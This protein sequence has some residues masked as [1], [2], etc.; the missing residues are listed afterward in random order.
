MYIPDSRWEEPN[1]LIPGKKPVRPVQIDWSRSITKD[2]LFCIL[3]TQGV[4]YGKVTISLVG[5]FIKGV[6]KDGPCWRDPNASTNRSSYL[7]L[8]VLDI[9]SPMGDF[10]VLTRASRARDI[11]GPD[12]A[13]LVDFRSVSSENQ[14]NLG[15]GYGLLADDPKPRIA[16]T[17]SDTPAFFIDGVKPSGYNPAVYNLTSGKYYTIVN[18]FSYASSATQWSLNR[19]ETGGVDSYFV[20]VDISAHFAWKRKLS[21]AEA[22]SISDNPYQFLIPA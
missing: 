20:P 15:N 18:T 5:N 11:S 17:Y 10:T 6:G 3:P 9:P 7:G 21:D 13:A 4:V 22:L 1:L 14:I 2:L 12:I 16:G 8:S 19:G